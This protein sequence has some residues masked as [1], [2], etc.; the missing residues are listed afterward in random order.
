MRRCRIAS[1]M[2]RGVPPTG[3]H[4]GVTLECRIGAAEV[5]RPWEKT[6]ANQATSLEGEPSAR[7]TPRANEIPGTSAGSHSPKRSSNGP[8]PHKPR[9]P[10]ALRRSAATRDRCPRSSSKPP[11]RVELPRQNRS[12]RGGPNN[13]RPARPRHWQRPDR[14]QLQWARRPSLAGLASV[15]EGRI[16]AAANPATADVRV[17]PASCT[18]DRV[19][20]FSVPLRRFPQA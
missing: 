2:P 14:S 19:N 17:L 13:I 5:H 16:M 3:M 6:S 10:G 8:L 7:P 4:R 11:A 20:Q 12:A 15:P 9:S 18:T 1:G